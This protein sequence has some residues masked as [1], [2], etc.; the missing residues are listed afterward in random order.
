MMRSWPANAQI[1]QICRLS[2]TQPFRMRKRM[3]RDSSRPWNFKGDFFESC[4]DVDFLCGVAYGHWEEDEEEVGDG[5]RGSRVPG[6]DRVGNWT[7][8]PKLPCSIYRLKTVRKNPDISISSTGSV[9][10]MLTQFFDHVA[11]AKMLF[12]GFASYYYYY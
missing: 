2:V 10:R 8:V 5:K 12:V 7:A 6:P 9:D 3:C 11:C 4:E 1:A